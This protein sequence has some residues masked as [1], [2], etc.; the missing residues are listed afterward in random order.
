VPHF[1]YKVEPTDQG[2][3]DYALATRLSYLLTGGPPDAEL[4][5]HAAAGRMRDDLQSEMDRLSALPS[6]APAIAQL[7]GAWLGLDRLT[8][9]ELASAELV[10]AMREETQAFFEWHASSDAPMTALFTEPITFL[11]ASMA[12]HYTLPAPTSARQRFDLDP[13]RHAGALTQ[14]SARLT[15]SRSARRNNWR[16]TSAATPR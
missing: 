12:A 10:Q 9:S 3:S 16:P 5:S 8:A 15:N 7:Y 6:F 1:L 2:H 13:T 14:G 11:D 4:L